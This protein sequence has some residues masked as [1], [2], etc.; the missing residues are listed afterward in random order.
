MIWIAHTAVKEDSLASDAG[1]MDEVEAV[2]L[3][4]SELGLPCQTVA[5]EPSLLDFLGKITS[6]EDN[7][8]FN[9]VESFRDSPWGETWIASFYEAFRLPYTGSP[10][11]ALGLC[12]DKRRARSVLQGIGLPVAPGISI[13]GQMPNL[14]AVS[15]PAI[16]KPACRDASEGLSPDCVI[17]NPQALARKVEELHHRGFS[18]LLLEKYIK[19]REFSLTLLQR[20]QWQVVSVFEVDF[21]GLPE[22][23]PHILC[24]EAKWA[25]ESVEYEGTLTNPLP[26]EPEL[27]ARLNQI[28]IQAVQELGLRDYVRIDM[29]YSDEGQAFIIDVNPNPDISL[30]GGFF[31]ALASANIQFKDFVRQIIQNARERTHES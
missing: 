18:P 30:A 27:K 8:V 25:Y 15:F 16:L 21:K 7:L 28:A 6:A 10:P 23:Q 4:L 17:E 29:R 19:G 3:A 22:G 2:Q 26:G 5:P 12:L 14:D 11:T 24:Y 31:R 13:D 20:P 9:L 1:V